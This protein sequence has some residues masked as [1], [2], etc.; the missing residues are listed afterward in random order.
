VDGLPA[1]GIVLQLRPTESTLLAQEGI[2][3]GAV[4]GP[5]GKFEVMTYEAGDGAP[6]GEYAII[7]FWP[8]D[9]D[10]PL[11]TSGNQSGDS[12][13]SIPAGPPDR[14][15][16]K[17]FDPRKTKWSVVVKETEIEIPVIQL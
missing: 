4:T 14:F 10:D 8:P 16:G 1:K 2:F 13:Q 9:F 6:Q 3:P 15:G 12:V 17:Y 11:A 5:D 7:L